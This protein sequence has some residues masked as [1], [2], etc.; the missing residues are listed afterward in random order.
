MINN[1]D[2]KVLLVDDSSVITLALE[3]IINSQPDMRVMGVATDPYEAVSI[4]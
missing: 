2:L 1:E 3:R 4:I